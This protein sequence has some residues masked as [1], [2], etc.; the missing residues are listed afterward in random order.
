MAF[1]QHYKKFT[2]ANGATDTF[3][4]PRSL[5]L[6]R[7]TIWAITDARTVTMTFQTR[8]NGNAYNAAVTVTA[9]AAADVVYRSGGAVSENDLI[10]F[11]PH[12]NRVPTA[13]ADPFTIDVLITNN[14]G[15]DAQVTM[16]AVAI[17]HQT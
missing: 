7:L 2:I 3:T 13:T 16:F 14:S 10:P 17:L 15:A 6:D 11:L 1:W 5:P 12:P 9:R 4:L 8:I